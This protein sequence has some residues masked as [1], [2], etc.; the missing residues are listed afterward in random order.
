MSTVDRPMIRMVSRKVNFAPDA[1]AEGAEHQPAEWAG[2]IGHGGGEQSEDIG[3]GG[4]EPGEDSAATI[5]A[6]GP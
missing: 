5:A 4:I 6:V 3:I 2:D 1:V